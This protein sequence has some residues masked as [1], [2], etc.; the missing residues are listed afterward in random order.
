M[1]T[2]KPNREF[3]L[4]LIE[5]VLELDELQFAELHL[6]SWC[7]TT[8]YGHA[9][10]LLETYIKQNTDKYTHVELAY[11]STDDFPWIVYMCTENHV[12]GEILVSGY[13]LALVICRALGKAITGGNLEEVCDLEEMSPGRQKG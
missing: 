3:D 13:P 2:D 9:L 5:H 6:E 1:N 8:S 11:D 10:F 12:Q 4:W 7:P